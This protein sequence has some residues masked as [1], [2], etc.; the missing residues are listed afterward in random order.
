MQTAVHPITRRHRRNR[1]WL[2]APFAAVVA[3]L[4]I[5]GPAGAAT[6]PLGGATMQP[7]P[8]VGPTTQSIIMRDG[9]ICDPIRHM[10]C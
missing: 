9:G 2:A 3:G 6:G 4:A 5:C 10:G 8:T 7:S 1:A